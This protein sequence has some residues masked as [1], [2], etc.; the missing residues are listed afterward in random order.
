MG[1]KLIHRKFQIRLKWKIYIAASLQKSDNGLILDIIM[2]ITTAFWQHSETGRWE[3]NISEFWPEHIPSKIK[4]FTLNPT[5]THQYTGATV[6]ALVPNLIRLFQ[7]QIFKQ[8][9]AQCRPKPTG[10]FYLA[11]VM[12]ACVGSSSAL[13]ML[14]SASR[15][16]HF[17]TLGASL[18][19]NLLLSTHK[20]S[21]LPVREMLTNS[22]W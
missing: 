2:K 9:R 14:W 18:W 19:S 3:N 8:H 22:Y 4:S 7:V 5:V 6:V 21:Y 16:G 15:Q 12:L 1:P 10:I 13:A 17:N 11:P 20:S